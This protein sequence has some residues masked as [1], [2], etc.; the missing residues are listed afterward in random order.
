MTRNTLLVAGRILAGT[1]PDDAV[2]FENPTITCHA[3]LH[4]NVSLG[5][6]IIQD[7]NSNRELFNDRSTETCDTM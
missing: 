2:L 7:R 5:C 1:A 4:G 6:V 3:L